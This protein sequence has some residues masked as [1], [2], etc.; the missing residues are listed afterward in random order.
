MDLLANKQVSF[1]HTRSIILHF[2][3]TALSFSGYAGDKDFIDNARKLLGLV[4]EDV[5]AEEYYTAVYDGPYVIIDR[6]NEVIFRI[7]E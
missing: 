2:Q 1:R 4:T 6:H 7:K 3:A 5:D